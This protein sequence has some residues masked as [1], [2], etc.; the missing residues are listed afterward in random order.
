MRLLLF[1]VVHVF[2]M[3]DIFQRE[4]ILQYDSKWMHWEV[5]QWHACFNTNTFK[6][7]QKRLLPW[8]Y[9][10]HSYHESSKG[11]VD[12]YPCKI[13]SG[14]FPYFL[15]EIYYWEYNKLSSRYSLDHFCC[16][17]ACHHSCVPLRALPFLFWRTYNITHSLPLYDVWRRRICSYSTR[18]HIL[19]Y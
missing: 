6:L 4:Y 10:F 15:T 16:E 12:L 9:N 17:K 2:K 3:Q 13:Y 5:F 19:H 14:K 18:P 11:V 7:R 8:F 1:W